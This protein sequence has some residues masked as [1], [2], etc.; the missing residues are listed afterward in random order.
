MSTNAMP[1]APMPAAPPVPPADTSAMVPPDMGKTLDNIMGELGRLYRQCHTL[2]PDSPLCDAVMSVQ[3][4]M[5]E[6][7]RNVGMPEPPVDPMAD[8]AAAGGDPMMGPNPVP[9]EADPMEMPPPPAGMDPM[10]AAAEDTHNMMLA[11]KKRRG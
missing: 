9:P 5:S 1:A 4:A 10:R 6:I 2:A 7:G 8:P 3:K 11:D